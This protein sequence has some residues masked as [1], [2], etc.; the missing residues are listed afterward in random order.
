MGTWSAVVFDNNGEVICHPVGREDTAVAALR[1]LLEV[2]S[3]QIFD[4]YEAT[5]I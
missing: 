1:V 2:T 3:N 4:K 5:H